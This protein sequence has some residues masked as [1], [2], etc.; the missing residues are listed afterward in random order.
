MLSV[1]ELSK[2]TTYIHY[3][4]KQINTHTGQVLHRQ[5]KLKL[6]HTQGLESKNQKTDTNER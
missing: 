2:L 1:Q 4:D 5:K 3:D 6:T